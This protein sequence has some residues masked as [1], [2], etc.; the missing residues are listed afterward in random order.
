MCKLIVLLPQ[1][2]IFLL[3]GILQIFSLRKNWPVQYLFTSL[4]AGKT[5]LIHDLKQVG[6]LANKCQ[7]LNLIDC[8]EHG[9]IN[10]TT[11][12]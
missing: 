6:V 9:H 4:F 7:S 11:Y 3:K 8:I 1:Q 5:D 12:P 2:V 10:L